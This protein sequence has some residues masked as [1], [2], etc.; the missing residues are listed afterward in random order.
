[1]KKTTETISRLIS[2]EI[3][4]ETKNGNVK[5][6]TDQDGKLNIGSLYIQGNQDTLVVDPVN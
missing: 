1:M 5:I 2:D 3:L 4:L 6:S